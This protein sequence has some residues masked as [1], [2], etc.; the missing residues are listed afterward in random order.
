MIE[1]QISS[2]N[3]AH[4]DLKIRLEE[5]SL[6]RKVTESAELTY[7]VMKEGK[8]VYEGVAAIHQALD[9]LAS[10]QEEWYKCNCDKFV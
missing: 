2:N 9:E 5:M 1:L 4:Q 3:L 8:Q 6:A 7:P 10:F